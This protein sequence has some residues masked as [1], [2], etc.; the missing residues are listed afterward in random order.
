MQE[1][2]VVVVTGASAG[3]GRAIA[4][5]FARAGWSVGLLARGGEGLAGAR[6]EIEALG[7]R[8]CTVE[9]D[10]A[11]ANAI[12]RAADVVERE[13]G[14]IAVWV[15]N[16]MVTI[17]AASVDVAPDEWEQVTRVTYLG[18][19]YGAL[20]ALKRMRPRNWGAVV[21]V[22]SALAYR[23]IP[24]QAPYCAAKSAVRGFVDSLRSELMAEGSGVR[25]SMVHLPAVNTPQFDWARNKFDRKLAPVPPIYQ[26]ETVATA[27]LRAAR[28]T[29]RE[30]WLGFSAVKA[31]VAQMIAPSVADRVLARAGVANET[32]N[33]PAERPRPDNLFAAG[34]GDPGAHGRFDDRASPH[35]TAFDPGLLRAAFGLSLAAL[36]GAAAFGLARRTPPRRLPPRED[37]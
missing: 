19:V 21:F 14:P 7:G 28:E 15:N 31:I 20:A 29:P 11:D 10:V 9:T 24:Y 30:I 32:T 35:A 13:L 6:R 8:A 33:Q 18:Q 23:S 3:V 5:A 4:V 26:P 36:A 17:Y 27:V 25:L 1:D 34:R 2:R 12:E 22:G 37:G 16:A